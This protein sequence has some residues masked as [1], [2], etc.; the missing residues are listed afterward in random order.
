MIPEWLLAV[1]VDLAASYYVL[2]RPE[3]KRALVVA[4]NGKTVSRLRNGRR[5]HHFPSA[6]PGGSRANAGQGRGCNPPPPPSAD[7]NGGGLPRMRC[8]KRLTGACKVLHPRLHIL[9]AHE[10]ILRAR[11]ALLAVVRFL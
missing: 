8:T 3:G 9:R 10:D 6:L 5:L 1:P 2:P 11:H 7:A 4:S